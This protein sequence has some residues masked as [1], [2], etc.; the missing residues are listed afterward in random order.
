MAV[1]L[2]AVILHALNKWKRWGMVESESIQRLIYQIPEGDTPELTITWYEYSQG[3]FHPASP[4]IFIF[5]PNNK[6]HLILDQYATALSLAEFSVMVVRWNEPRNSPV[7][8][9]NI[10]SK[11]SKIDG[12]S[13]LELYTKM[14][15][16]KN[17]LDNQKTIAFS[18]RDQKTKTLRQRSQVMR[19]NAIM[20]LEAGNKDAVPL[21]KCTEHCLSSPINQSKVFIIFRSVARDIISSVS[22]AAKDPQNQWIL[23]SPEIGDF[24]KWEIF[25]DNGNNIRVLYSLDSSNRFLHQIQAIIAKLKIPAQNLAPFPIGGLNLAKQETVC[26]AKIISWISIIP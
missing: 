19:N 25:S 17:S 20:F 18:K 5:S 24:G 16:L 23:I 1:L 10:A 7:N 12:K 2:V 9:A 14:E 22:C 11:V 4:V 8:F 21:G 13:K 6:Y 3:S 26:L 15:T